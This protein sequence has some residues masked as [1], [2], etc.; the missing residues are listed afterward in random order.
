MVDRAEELRKEAAR[1]LAQ[2]KLTSD[3]KRREELI[4]MAARFHDLASSAQADFDAILQA[5]NDAK[6]SSPTSENVVQ[7]QQQVQPKKDES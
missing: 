5:F 3:P 6:M 7:Q 1:C 2:A 4:S